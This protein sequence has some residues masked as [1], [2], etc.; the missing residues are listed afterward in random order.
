MFHFAKCH[1]LVRN[2]NLL[3]R[4]VC[5]SRLHII[6]QTQVV[7][8]RENEKKLQIIIHNCVDQNIGFCSLNFNY[9]FIASNLKRQRQRQRQ[10]KWQKRARNEQIC[11]YGPCRNVQLQPAG[12]IMWLVQTH[13]HT[14]PFQFLWNSLI[15]AMNGLIIIVIS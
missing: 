9:Q 7:R 6:I 2:R 10:T 1:H 11:W 8:E 5:Y 4:N 3:D 15:F 13:K 14:H 12:Y